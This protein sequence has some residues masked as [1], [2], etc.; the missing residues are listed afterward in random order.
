[1]DNLERRAKLYDWFNSG[2]GQ[3]LQAHEANALRVVL[4]TL[5]G[6]VAMQLGRLG[7]LDLLDSCNA[8]SRIVLDLD[9]RAQNIG[10]CA[11]PEELPFEN[12]SADVALLPHTLDFCADPHQVLRETARVL[13][14]EGHVVILGFNPISLWGLRS[15]LTR[16]PK[17]APWCGNFFRLARI[18][19][20]LLLLDFELT[21]G[22]MLFYRP[23]LLSERFMQR[24]HFLDSMGDRWWPLMA[25]VYLI[26]AKKRVMGMTPMPLEWKTQKLNPRF[27]AQ[28]ATR[29]IVVPFSPR[30]TKPLG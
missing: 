4:P 19:D 3:A 10:V 8:P 28:G 18:K 11:L 6:T 27:A 26:V 15:L 25:A 2:L 22:R 14:P 17:Q 7:S 13:S 1:M 9:A 5:Y 16:K 29:G 12:K 24:L 20:W 21:H 23:P 30:R